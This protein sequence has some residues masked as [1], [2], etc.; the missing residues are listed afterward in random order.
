MSMHSIRRALLII[1]LLLG[2]LAGCQ[3]TTAPAS[4]PKLQFAQGDNGIW[5]VNTLDDHSDNSCDDTDCTL[6][7]AVFFAGSGGTIRFDASFAGQ[8]MVLS[9]AIVLPDQD[10]SIVGPDD[11][12]TISGNNSTALFYAP[13]SG[14]IE[15][16]N[17]T[18]TGA[19]GGVVGTGHGAA[20]ING[21]ADLRIT[22]TTIAN[23][24][25]V[26]LYQVGGS[27]FSLNNT[28][29]G[30]GDGI[31]FS[32]GDAEFE[33]TTIVNNTGAGIE[34][35][36]GLSLYNT[37][38][39]NNGVD[40][41]P[42]PGSQPDFIEGVNLDSDGTCLLRSG[43]DLIGQDPALGPLADNGGPNYTHAVPFG[44]VVDDAAGC[45]WNL[46]QRYVS[47]PQGASCEIGAYERIPVS[48]ALA[49]GA[50]GTVNPNDGSVT[51]TGTLTCTSA[52]AVDLDITVTQYQMVRRVRVPITSTT[53]VTVGCNGAAN[54]SATVAPPSAHSFVNG[55]AL[56]SAVA[57][58]S[59]N[60]GQASRTV[61]L[62]WAKK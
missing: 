19:D 12:I 23:N 52:L 56:V 46:D 17:L 49:M 9:S 48:V 8:T 62:F 10:F 30:N 24:L 60:A 47:R 22:H 6:R 43:V 28:I 39:A 14:S 36:G 40:C 45:F 3:E 55:S 35:L 42:A 7:E 44:S 59:D 25:G 4:Y 1:P 37:V 34:Y 50:S 51:V 5:T 57:A 2:I 33:H 54:W 41:D 15:L 16:R 38:I 61:K 21:G 29:S 32:G 11:G 27:T 58:N 31:A 26:G 53:T 13:S 18:L 20:I